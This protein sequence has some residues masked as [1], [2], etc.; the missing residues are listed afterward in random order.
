MLTLSSSDIKNYLR[1]TSDYYKT[2]LLNNIL[3]FWFNH[4]V[5]NEYGGFTFS[6]DKDGSILDT[7]KAMWIH[8]RYVWLLSELYNKVENKKKWLELATHGIEF[9]NKYGFDDDGRMFFTTTREGKPLRKRRYLFTE[10]FTCMAYASYARASGKL[11]YA[12]KSIELF[13]FILKYIQGPGLLPEKTLSETRPMKSHSVAMINIVVGQVLRETL[14]DPLID[15][16]ILQSI[17]EIENDFMKDEFNAILETVGPN[18]EFLDSFD[19]RLLNP[20]HAN[21]TAWF[22]MREGIYRSDDK[23]KNLGLKIFDWSWD[24][25]WDKDY[26]GIIYYRDV[27]NRPSPEYWHDMKFWWPQCE[28]IVASLYAYQ[29]TKDIKYLE[30]HK[31]IHDYTFNLFP[32]KEFGEWFGY[33]HRDGR[34][35]N[36]IKGNMWKGPF[37]IPRMLLTSWQLTEKMEDV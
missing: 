16:A 10:A 34:L 14:K 5:D 12:M 29:I 28:A 6:L 30:K 19:G 17:H 7:D 2:Q 3:P 1:V 8:G 23:I 37:H 4:S 24:W 26:G 20:G 25:G 13:K 35:S 18:G 21:E 36:T 32:D 15:E 33:F 11:E 22:I 9:I 27:K 31:L